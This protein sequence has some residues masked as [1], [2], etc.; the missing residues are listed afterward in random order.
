MP[1]T[2]EIV[3][4]VREKLEEIKPSEKKVAAFVSGPCVYAK[5]I[6]GI[7]AVVI[8]NGYSE[9]LRTRL[10]TSDDEEF[11]FLFVDSSLI[12][13]DITKGALGDFLTDKLLYP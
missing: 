11:R 5:R 7:N 9:G 1:S 12:E 8:C 3:E 13:S 6:D 4:M 2:S 10:L